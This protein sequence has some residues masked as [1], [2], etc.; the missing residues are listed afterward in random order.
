MMKEQHIAGKEKLMNEN[1]VDAIWWILI[2]YTTL[3]RVKYLWFGLKVR[4]TRSCADISTK[5]ILHTNIAYW[6]MFAHNFNVADLKDQF[7][8]GFGIVTT[9]FSAIMLWNYRDDKTD[10]V[11]QWIVKGLLGKLKDEGGLLG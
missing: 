6:I 2:G 3:I 11:A 8:W 5:A 9:L 10:N 7:F 4:R 1:I